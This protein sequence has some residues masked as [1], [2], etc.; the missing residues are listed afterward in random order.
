MR[1]I[2]LAGILA[3]ALTGVFAVGAAFSQIY[4]QNYIVEAIIT[5]VASPELP[6]LHV[7]NVWST[8][9]YR[10]ATR[11]HT[12]VR[13][14]GEAL[15]FE[16]Q[17]DDYFILKRGANSTSA[18]AFDLLRE[19]LGIRRLADYSSAGALEQCSVKSHIP[20]LVKVDDD[21]S[22]ER[23]RQDRVSGLYPEFFM[24]IRVSPTRLNPDYDLIGR[25]PWISDLPVS[26]PSSRPFTIPEEG[27]FADAEH[28]QKDFVVEK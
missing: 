13:V 4:Q 20:M 28:Y 14:F 23:V 7:S 22:I 8:I 15:H 19:C 1:R 27:G 5:P 24:E 2:W 25:F 6:A 18:G 26:L 21:G 12:V 9:V 11:F 10:D 3:V 16:F 17:N